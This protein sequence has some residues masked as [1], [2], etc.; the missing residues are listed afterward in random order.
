VVRAVA[1]AAVGWLAWR[2][3]GLGWQASVLV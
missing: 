3:L 2:F 1:L